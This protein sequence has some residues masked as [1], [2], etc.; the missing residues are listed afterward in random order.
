M[1]AAVFD[2]E[3]SGLDAVGSGTLLCVVIKPLERREIIFRADE[4]KC[5]PGREKRLVQ[6]VNDELNKYDLL[7]GHNIARFD[8][9]WLRSRAVFFNL[10]EPR[11]PF[12]Y[13]TLPAFRRMG[14]KTVPNHFGKP[15]ASLGHV[16][17]FFGIEQE[18]T[19]IF[20]RAHWD[21]VWKDG[22]QRKEAMDD[23]VSHCYKDVRMTERVY[24]ELIK[25]DHAASIRR[26]R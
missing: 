3:T 19:S 18:K 6:A 4:L 12:V 24:W 26:V 15:S 17:D 1:K 8:L 7:I 22:K 9:A 25:V 5:A 10:P 21:I 20:P 2:I 23:L 14:Y 13:D 16:V 11:R